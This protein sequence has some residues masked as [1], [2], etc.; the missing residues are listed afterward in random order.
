MGQKIKKENKNTSKAFGEE[1]NA[2]EIKDNLQISIL[3]S[4][5]SKSH[6]LVSHLLLLVMSNNLMNQTHEYPV[7]STKQVE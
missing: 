3:A 4:V 1:N 5:R 7:H 6:I 2:E